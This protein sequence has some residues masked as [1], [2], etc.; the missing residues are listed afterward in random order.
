[1]ADKRLWAVPLLLVSAIALETGHTAEPQAAMPAAKLPPSPLQQAPL[2][3]LDSPRARRALQDGRAHKRRGSLLDAIRAYQEA[4]YY[5]AGDSYIRA[6]AQDE[7]QFHLPLMR[8]QQL[9]ALGQRQEALT[10]V[11]RLQEFHG[12]DPQRVQVLSGVLA[13][14]QDPAFH[15]R[16]RS[17]TLNPAQVMAQVQRALDGYWREHEEFPR[18]YTELNQLL[19]ADN[20]PLEQFDII[21]YS[22]N[23]PGY[24]LELRAKKPPH[25][26]YR[27]EKTG[28]LR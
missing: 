9:M 21:A 15:P 22:R 17:K 20:P 7:L 8:V 5:S 19:P 4:Y 28:L 1:M 16:P 13:K 26:T 10:I 11:K 18:G 24:R 6:E 25:N 2:S 14:V 23:G 27:I 3:G 12:K